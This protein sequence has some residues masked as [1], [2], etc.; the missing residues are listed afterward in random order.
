MFC[1]P[2]ALHQER[3]RP[4]FPEGLLKIYSWTP[5]PAGAGLPTPRAVAPAVGTAIVPAADAPRPYEPRSMTEEMRERRED[6]IML[7]LGAFGRSG[8]MRDGAGLHS[9][10]NLFSGLADVTRYPHGAPRIMGACIPDPLSGLYALL[11]VLII[12]H[13]LKR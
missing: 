1:N 8:P 6:V 3:E 4:I 11:A 2:A 10:A 5:R 9:A 12:G 7:S 13:G